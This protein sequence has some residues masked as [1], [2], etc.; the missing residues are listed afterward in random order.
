MKFME[1]AHKCHN[2]SHTKFQTD[3]I[4]IMEILQNKHSSYIEDLLELQK[5]D[6]MGC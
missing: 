3:K 2:N 1:I 6:S 5:C 4:Q